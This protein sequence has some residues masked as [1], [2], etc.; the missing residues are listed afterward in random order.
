[1]NEIDILPFSIYIKETTVRLANRKVSIFF[2]FN[3]GG[4][5]LLIAI[6]FIFV[7]DTKITGNC[8]PSVFF[9]TLRE[10]QQ[11]RLSLLIHF[12]ILSGPFCPFL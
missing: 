8:F 9:I 3:D 12:I 6:Y 5:V 7:F 1:M 2:V 4:I 11:I 10:L